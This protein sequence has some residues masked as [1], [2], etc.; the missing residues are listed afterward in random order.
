MWPYER[1]VCCLCV[2]FFKKKKKIKY[3][4]LFMPRS[5]LKV[6]YGFVCMKFVV[7]F[8]IR[9]PTSLSCV[10]VSK[11]EKKKKKKKKKK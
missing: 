6:Y 4:T 9:N 2:C 8:C 1:C 11:I 10:S 5:F 7:C 3:L